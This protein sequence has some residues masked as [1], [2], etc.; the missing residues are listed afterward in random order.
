LGR[1]RIAA[2]LI[3]ACVLVHAAR[4][5]ATTC[6]PPANADPRVGLI[7]GRDR[8]LWID[9]RINREAARVRL[10]SRAWG[11]GIGA[12]G[13]GSLAAVPFVAP[14]DRVDWY[15]G[16]VSAAVGVV[17]FLIS[18]L[19]V[20]RDAPRVGAAV[21]AT[22]ADDDAHIC[23]TLADAERSLVAAADSEHWQRGWWTHAGNIAFN[24]G[25]LLFLGLGYHHWVSGIVNGA[26]GAA[27]GEAIIL[28]QPTGSISDLRAY[29]RG[30]L[31]IASPASGRG[32]NLTKFYIGAG[33]A[34]ITFE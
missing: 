16:A 1:R 19:T 10:W 24:A 9:Q 8:L 27:V 17:P 26:S 32:E 18:P 3:A 2:A 30:D 34:G 7:D 4:A 25:I 14:S 28:T 31:P 29:A 33:G 13:L 12:A 22:P 11:I 23:A 20:T 5:R 6:A 15:T 21:A